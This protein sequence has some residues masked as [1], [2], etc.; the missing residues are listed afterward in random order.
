MWQLG[1]PLK[2]IAVVAGLIGTLSG[3][4]LLA[5]PVIASTS[6]TGSA[7]DHEAG[8]PSVKTLTGVISLEVSELEPQ[9]GRGVRLTARTDK[10]ADESF[11]ITIRRE[12]GHLSS[13]LEASCWSQ[14]ICTADVKADQP[15]SRTFAV[16]L[17]RCDEK[18]MCVLERDA[19]VSEKTLVN[20]R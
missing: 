3:V 2:Q 8:S 12:G 7:T 4:S 20:W 16:A 6:G 18:G 9:S 11:V 5:T 1:R 13:G 17:Y 19:S 14:P 15:G 10:S